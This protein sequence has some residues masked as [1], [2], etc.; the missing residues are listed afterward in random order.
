MKYFV[1]YIETTPGVHSDTGNIK[2][3]VVE[4]DRLICDIDGIKTI[5]SKIHSRVGNHGQRK[6]TVINFQL[7]PQPVTHDKE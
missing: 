7:L 5:E 6:V 3:T 4:M 2:N 1:C